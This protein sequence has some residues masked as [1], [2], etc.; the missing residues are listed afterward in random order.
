MLSKFK[1]LTRLDIKP[2]QCII[3]LGWFLLANAGMCLLLS[4]NLSLFGLDAVLA[5]RGIGLF[6]ICLFILT[7]STLGALVLILGSKIIIRFVLRARIVG[8][9]VDTKLQQLKIMVA[10]QAKVAGIRTP[11]LAIYDS[12]ERNAFAVGSGR[13][14]SM[15]VLSQPLLETLTLDELSA[16]IG[17]E[18]THIT[19]GDM[20]ALSMMQ[21]VINTFVHFPARLLGMGPDRLFFRHSQVGPFYK[22]FSL[23][24]QLAL[25][26]ITSLI[27]MHFSRQRE[28][29]ADAGGARLAGYPEMLAALRSLQAGYQLD[30]AIHPFMVFGLTGHLPDAGFWRL[31]TSHPTLAERI[32]A[33]LNTG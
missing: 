20:L 30:S 1:F 29:R 9:S 16:V 12:A 25:G 31:F 7:G 21:G 17:H 27:V 8:E 14:D 4:I 5:L 33:L 24:L 10:Q 15:L 2:A 6:D 11:V 26:G 22:I 3:P 28:F 13:R 19:N 23:F 32:R 18:I